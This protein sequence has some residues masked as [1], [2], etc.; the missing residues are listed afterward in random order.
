MSPSLEIEGN[1]HELFSGLE[2]MTSLRR[3]ILG[4]IYMVAVASIWTGANFMVQFAV[5]AGAPHFL[6]TYIR[7]S[8]FA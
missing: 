4:L 5:Y 2:D 8:L 7:N 1:Y 3:W 6:I